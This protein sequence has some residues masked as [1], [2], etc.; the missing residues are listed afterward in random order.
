MNSIAKKLI[1]YFTISLIIFSTII[2][3]IF[4]FIFKKYIHE[5]NINDLEK[6]AIN[7]ANSLSETVNYDF[8]KGK[9]NNGYGAYLKFIDDIAMSEVWI[10]NKDL[11]YIYRG[12]NE[13]ELTFS[14]LPKE[15][16]FIIIE[17]FQ[18]KTSHCE[19]FGKLFSK[20]T[21]SVGTPILDNNKNPIAVVL[22]HKSF[23]D[24]NL[25]VENGITILVI[26]IFIAFIVSIFSS[27]ILS[28]HF[29][30]PIKKIEQH[31]NKLIHGDYTIKTNINQ[32]DEIG[33]LAKSLDILSEKLY[34]ASEET[35]KIDKLRKDFISNIS[36]ELRTPVT[37][38]RG[39]LEALYDGIIEEK[40][41]QKKYY[42]QM[43]NE[44]IY[45]QRLVNDLLDLTKLQNTDF[46]IEIDSLNIK[47][48]LEDCIHSISQISKN[49][50]L[51]LNFKFD[52]DIFIFKGDYGRLRQ[53]FLIILDNAVKFSHENN[54]ID[55]IL[56]NEEKYISIL[57]Y[58]KGINNDDLPYIFDR[59]YK[60]KSENNKSGT[61][62]GLAIAKEIANKHNI[63]IEV[64]SKE[65]DFTNFKFLF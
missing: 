50:N 33:K 48:L 32:K 12:Q 46:K 7:I 37:V 15:S 44:S 36:H 3:I 31:T 22:L 5:K 63:K 65:N 25:A 54:S 23:D 10:I 58:G 62:L 60:T 42:K 16:E 9:K 59:F 30:K 53:M 29:V 8:N 14:S 56:N 20:Q 34:A 51:S 38:I 57:D 11:D 55:I 39:S 4:I 17:A 19:D 27:V 6:K 47:N 64:L 24:I 21:I 26:S 2:G 35:K 1:L 43:L 61:G 45:L 49:K 18:G 52:S 41:Q 28:F 40:E 13:K